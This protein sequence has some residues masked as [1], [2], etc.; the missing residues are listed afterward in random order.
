MPRSRQAVDALVQSAIL[1]LQAKRNTEDD[2]G[3]E[4][5]REWP[6]AEKVRQ[7][8]GAAN[9]LRGDELIY[10]IGVD[11]KTG[12]IHTPE[13]REPMEWF[14]QMA[15]QFDQIAPEMLWSQT[16]YIGNDAEAVTAVVFATQD[17]PYILNIKGSDRREVPLRVGAATVS[18]HRNQL[19]RMLQPAV[20][21]PRISVA[22]VDGRV[23]ELLEARPLRLPDGSLR[24]EEWKNLQTIF[25]VAVDLEFPSLDTDL[26]SV[27]ERAISARAIVDEAK[28][29]PLDVQ[30]RETRPEIHTTRGVQVLGKMLVA[31]GP[32]TFELSLWAEAR[33][34][35]DL[36]PSYQS[37]ALM[38]MYADTVEIQI[39]IRPSGTDSDVRT[40]CNLRSVRVEPVQ[41]PTPNSRA[42]KVLSG[43]AFHAPI[44]DPW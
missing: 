21:L 25:N 31:D 4:F 10:V 7:L 20:A 38:W 29:F 19:V 40:T 32:G 18:A 26:V 44:Y 1:N 12:K 36:F 9:A 3:I 15:K 23:Q 16:V 24:R 22:G 30:L 33:D 6:G 37:Q 43:W 13:Q 11:D 42:M 8:A 28:I 34:Q 17:F 35:P 27:S 2:A 5:K 41:P 39:S 14:A